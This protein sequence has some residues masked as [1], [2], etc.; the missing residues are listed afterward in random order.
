MYAIIEDSG[1]QTL[2]SEGDV[3]KIDLRELADDAET[4]TFDKVMLVRLGDTPTSDE[5]EGAEDHAEASEAPAGELKIGTPYVE[6]ARVTGQILEEGRDE[7]VEV[8]KFKRRKNYRRRMGHRQGFIRVK[9]TSI[10]A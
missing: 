7:K 9:I 4:V 3:I 10:E 1:T 5:A 8:V 2:V 6:G